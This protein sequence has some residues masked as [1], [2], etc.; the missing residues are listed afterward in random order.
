MNRTRKV[1]VYF[2]FDLLAAAIAWG[3]FFVWRK[4]FLEPV[5]YGEAI[6][7]EFDTNFYL[8]LTF[9]P[10][11]WVL[12]YASTGFYKDI[13]RKSRLNEL[14]QTLITALIGTLVLFFAVL[15]DDAISSYKNYYLSYLMLFSL[16]FFFTFLFRF[17]ITT[18]TLKKIQRRE[19]GFRTVIIGSNEKALNLYNEIENQPT[20]W[21][22]TI[23]GYAHVNGNDT[24]GLA[25]HI[26]DLGNVE[27]IKK[28]VTDNQIEEVILAIESS[29]HGRIE[30]I[31]EDLE[32]IEVL[33]KIIPD[34]YDILSGSVKMTSIF[35]TP[36]IEVNSEIMPQWEVTAKR[37]F[38][39]L[40]SLFVLV[41]CA[42]LYLI[43]GLIVKLSS[44][45]P[46]IFS[47]ERI[48]LYSKPFT[49]YK[50]R[51]MYRNAETNG[52]LLSSKDDERITKFGKFM[53]KTRLDEMPQF[54]NVLIGDMSLVGPRPERQYYIDQILKEAS[55]YNHLLK[56]RP[57][58]TSWGQVK[59]GYAENVQEMTERL[60]YD[61]LYI[62]NMS[63]MVDF[64]I[65][66]YTILIVLKGSG[67]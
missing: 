51:S 29:E 60:K 5:T 12:F 38:D 30:K 8:G 50:F 49:I 31:I 57:G 16:H 23:V 15:L 67:K 45:G 54:Y 28:I 52:P 4:R 59:Y 14:G 32:G 9:I 40:V 6:P 34:M 33:I 11:L 27:E 26:Q 21:G 53:R 19:I 20:G 7:I 62:E 64:K 10:I 42:P 39:I 2:V 25:H 13:Y 17:I 41:F 56:V 63:L 1:I 58:I 36:L 44:P 46:A 37:T 55:H 18:N 47:Q 43:I 24:N 65:L 22:H 3:S 48:G 61:I 35:G 66:I